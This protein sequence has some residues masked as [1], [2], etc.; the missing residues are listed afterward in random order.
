MNTNEAEYSLLIKARNGNKEA[1][2]EIVKIYMRRA[3][4]SALTLLGS[5]EDALDISQEAFIRAYRAIK[6]FDINKKFFTWYYQI[7][8]NLCLNHLRD[9]FRHAVNFSNIY[10]LLE[11]IKDNGQDV[12][13]MVERNETKKIVWEALWKLPPEDREIITAKDIVNASYEEIAELLQIPTGT[14][15]SRLYNA[16]KKLRKIIEEMR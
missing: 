1:Y 9:K 12:E 15:M 11:N 2:G 8:K 14:V 3:Y 13:I 5:H 7:L 6:K 4:F 10:E 16:R